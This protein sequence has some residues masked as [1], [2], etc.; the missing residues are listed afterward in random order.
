MLRR[1]LLLLI[2]L[3]LLAAADPDTATAAERGT[4]LF[5]PGGEIRGVRVIDA[6]GDGRRDLVVLLAP[7]TGPDEVL[8]LR[9]PATPVKRNFYPADHVTR[10]RCI[11]E[12]A[13]AGALAV[14]R[15]GPQGAVRLRFLSGRGVLDLTAKGTPAERTPR[16]EI[17]SLFARSAGRPL[18]FWDGVA[19]LD[20]D[21]IDECWYP[22]ATGAGAIR[23]FGGTP[24]GDRILDLTAKSRASSSGVHLMARHVYV[25]N[26]FPADLDGDGKREL[27]ALRDESLV[28]W[29]I[30]DKAPAGAT[31][32]PTF[33]VKLP[34]LAPDPD[35]APDELR[36]PRIQIEDVDGDGKADLL[37]TLITGVRSR[38]TSLRT[39]LFHYP[40]PFRNPSTGALVAPRAR[41]DTQS[42]V[43]HPTFV[44][45]DGDGDR[46]YVGDSIRGTMIDMIARM[47]GKD[48]EIFFV[49]FRYDKAAGTFERT[50]YFSVERMYASEEALS[51]R[52][53]R[54][55]SF[56]GDFDGDGHND[57]LDLGDLG[58]VEILRGVNSGKEASYQ[59]T[60]MKR[61]PVKEGLRADA[62]VADLNG[63]KRAD[64]VM[65]SKTK[66]YLVVSKGGAR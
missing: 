18:V 43:L 21:G 64:A 54:S 56:E 9:T 42:I 3:L 11:G 36:T 44:D 53:G 59:A 19:D 25:P 62:R 63:D 2:T 27:L 49:G 24:A 8:V 31:V 5:D 37:V 22:Q 4:Y 35:R 52:F 34:F 48:P 7:K 40:G 51:N 13:A 10:I 50:P 38:L 45:V 46:D 61:V 6:D 57:L 23:V 30:G 16:H 47:M 20:G 58:G 15:F 17:P 55:G 66:L 60:L 28:A 33:R 65:W 39:I 14:G 26:L 12:R 32:A 29:R 41:I 1:S